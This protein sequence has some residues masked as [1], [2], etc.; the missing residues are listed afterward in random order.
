MVKGDKGWI[1]AR[2]TYLRSVQNNLNK[3]TSNATLNGSQSHE[4][5][6]QTDDETAAAEVLLL[7]SVVVSEENME[8]IIEKLNLTRQYRQKMLLDKN[9]NLKEQFPYLFTDLSLVKWIFLVF[10]YFCSQLTKIH[11]LFQMTTEFELANPTVKASAFL[12]KWPAIFPQ[13]R[14]I[15]REHYRERNFKTDWSEN[16]ESIL[17]LLKMFPSRQIGRNVIASDATFKKSVEQF[18]HFE[19]VIL[20]MSV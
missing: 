8:T 18:I 3:S 16:V 5:V 15:L 2:L 13:L 11:A 4:I 20:F 6:A 19:P 1:N 12:D 10:S 7:K 17:V 9:M 14:N